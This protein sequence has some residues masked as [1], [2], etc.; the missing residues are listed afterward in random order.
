[1][2]T[3]MAA[4]P[5]APERGASFLSGDERPDLMVQR[6]T[7]RAAALARVVESQRLFTQIGQGKHLRVEAWQTLGA[8]TGAFGQIEWCRKIENGWE[9]RA[10]VKTL[11]G[12]QVGAAESMC[13]TTER[14]WRGRDDHAVR[15]MAQTRALSKALS[16]PLRFIVSLAGYDG[17][18]AEEMPTNVNLVFPSRTVKQPEQKTTTT[19]TPA[20]AAT[21]AAP[22]ATAGEPKAVQVWTGLIEK[23][24]VKTGKKKD[25]AAWKLYTIHA[26]EGGLKFATFSESFATDAKFAAEHDEPI[27]VGYSTSDYGMTAETLEPMASADSTEELPAVD[28]GGARGEE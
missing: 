22:K 26:R 10:V 5:A 15:S 9:A 14:N 13:L 4:V 3:E 12:Q 28:G 2:P 19:G 24:T 11:A 18:P 27:K 20:P 16:G 6:N 1:M 23:V 7:E 17:T 25:G 8:M 21:A